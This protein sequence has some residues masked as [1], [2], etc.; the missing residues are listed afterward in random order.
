MCGEPKQTPEHHR[1]VTDYSP[2]Y[3]LAPAGMPIKLVL[4]APAGLNDGS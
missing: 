4:G 3:T 2:V 1:Q